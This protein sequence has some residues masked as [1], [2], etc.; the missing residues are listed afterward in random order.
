MILSIPAGD[1]RPYI[2]QHLIYSTPAGRSFDM[3]REFTFRA[4]NGEM[5]RIY[6]VEHAVLGVN[7]PDALPLLRLGSYQELSADQVRRLKIYMVSTSRNLA[8]YNEVQ[9]Y[10]FLTTTENDVLLNRPQMVPNS[11]I[12]KGYSR[13]A[14]MQGGRL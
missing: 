13:E 9:D 10:Y 6:R 4:K 11:T 3:T 7:P 8:G 5:S 2:D 14:L 12:T 1:S